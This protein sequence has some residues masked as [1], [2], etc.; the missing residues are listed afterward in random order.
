MGKL[1]AKIKE[2][3]QTAFEQV[4]PFAEQH[5]DTNENQM[6]SGWKETLQSL[7]FEKQ[8]KTT[9]ENASQQFQ[10]DV[11]EAIEEIGNELKIINQLQGGSFKFKEQDSNFFDRDFVRISGMALIAA[12]AILAFVFPP[13]GLIGVVGGIAGWLA[14]QFKSRDQ[15]RHEAVGTISTS[16]RVQLEE[17]QEKVLQ[18]SEEHFQ[19]Y[20]QSVAVMVDG[21]FEELIQGIEAIAIQ[22]KSAQAKLSTA[23]NYL[24]KAYAKRIVDWASD[25][26]EPLTDIAISKKICKVNRVFGRNLQIQTTTT[27]TLTKSQEEICS[28][29]QE[30]VS[31]QP[32]KY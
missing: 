28:V 6:N 30:H 5:W 9:C 2:I 23:A 19:E 21:Y 22:L 3:F 8:L 24:N 10:H 13:L 7:A 15:K 16:L 32:T 25:Q 11:Q 29:L 27:L 4:T 31:I 20:C 18:Q 12:G 26:Y 17:Y 14:G 1:A